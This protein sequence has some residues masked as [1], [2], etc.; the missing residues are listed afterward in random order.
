LIVVGL[1]GYARS[2]KDTVADRLVEEHD[3]EKVSFA[4]PLKDMLLKL[5]PQVGVRWT[6]RGPK[7]VYLDDVYV[8][9]GTEEAVKASKYGEEIRGLWQRLGT[10]CVRKYDDLFWVRAAFQSLTDDNG[11]YVFTDT[12]FP[13]EAQSIQSLQDTGVVPVASLWNVTRPGVQPINNHAS[14]LH[15]GNMNE[16]YI[17]GND[18]TIHDLNN[19]VDQLVEIVVR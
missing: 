15:A 8:M 2:G 14:E 18:S 9:Y 19:S 12:R 7:P 5:N 3:F 4:K 16:D 17:I 13:N 11:R 10:D 6:W 1:T